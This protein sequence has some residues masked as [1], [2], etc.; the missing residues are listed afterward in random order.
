M[1]I[2]FGLSDQSLRRCVNSEDVII[3]LLGF[4]FGEIG[5]VVERGAGYAECNGCEAGGKH[6]GCVYHVQRSGLS[7]RFVLSVR[8]FGGNEYI[9]GFEAKACGAAQPNYEPLIN[10]FNLGFV[11]QKYTH[12][13]GIR[14][15]GVKNWCE[16]RYP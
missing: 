12:L 4:A 5:S 15:V 8:A 7:R 6:W 1:P 11:D 16:C 9:F 2:C 14:T 3:A 13:L 10:N